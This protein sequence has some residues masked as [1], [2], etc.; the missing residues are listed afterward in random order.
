MRSRGVLFSMVILAAT[1]MVEAKAG[2][3]ETIA[4]V[5]KAAGALDAAFE[6]QDAEAV[7][8]LMTPD[9]VAVTPYYDAPQDVAEQLATL[10]D[11]NYAQ[12]NL[13]E[14]QVTLLGPDAALRTFRAKL[15]GTFKGKPI[16]P[17][18]FVSQLMVKR[19]GV[20][21]ERFYQVTALAGGDK[22]P[23]SCKELVGTYLTE[24]VAK[25]GG[26]TSRS[27][28]SLGSAHL[29]LFT[30][31]GEGGEAG[32]APFT[33]G[34]GTWF[35]TEDADGALKVSAT[36]LDFTAATADAKPGI[37]R[38]DFNLAYSAGTEK[39]SGTATLYLL[40]LDADPLDPASLKDGRSFEVTGRRIG[41]RP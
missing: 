35:C 41:A 20:W 14:A 7:K 19:D 31:S 28:I 23:I 26:A 36:T 2:E 6:R 25:E 32:F 39:L 18:V 37:G 11:L 8:Q 1:C 22:K 12:T 9:H 33:D 4:E 15:D 21:M 34:R 5:N 13:D 27:L 16:A 3:A 30:D 40:S 29:I 24:N 38:L 10:T 17:N